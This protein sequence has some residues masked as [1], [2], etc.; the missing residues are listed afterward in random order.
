VKILFVALKYDYGIPER[1][2]SFEYYSF[3][4]TLVGM[5]HDVEYFDYYTLFKQHGSLAMTKMLRRKVEEWKPDL[6][7][8]F[9]FTDQFNYEELRKITTETNTIT[10]NWF[11]D[12]HWRFNNFSRHWAPCFSYV[13]TTDEKSVE[14]YT[15]AGYKNILLTQWAANPRI[16]KRGNGEINFGVTF[17]G[18]AHGIRKK[19]IQFLRREGIPIEVWGIMWRLHRIHSIAHRMHIF[20]DRTLERIIDSTRISQ[21]EMIDIIQVSKINLNLSAASQDSE[22]QIKGRNFE[23]P[24]CAGFQLSGYA[25]ALEKYFQM[26]REIVCY[27]TPEELAEKIRYYL[28]HEKERIAIAEAGY[29]RVCKEHTYTQR[30]TLLFQQMGIE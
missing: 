11:A 4:D 1:G 18:Q 15:A 6:L 5:G 27:R 19:V 20:S 9:L 17:I 3:Y 30:F 8:F 21:Q 13:S 29:Q 14:K 22:N 24:A 10:F 28:H 7:F 23:I 26:D 16:W 12:D 25:Y 2:Y